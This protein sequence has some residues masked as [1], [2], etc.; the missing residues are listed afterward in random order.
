MIKSEHPRR[1]ANITIYETFYKY[2]SSHAQTMKRCEWISTQCQQYP[3]WPQWLL[4]T[5]KPTNAFTP[6]HNK[7]KGS[8][9]LDGNE[10]HISFI[11]FLRNTSS[12]L[13]KLMHFNHESLYPELPATIAN[14]ADSKTT[15]FVGFFQKSTKQLFFHTF[16]HSWWRRIVSEL[17]CSKS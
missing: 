1:N 12:N 11:A 15:N 13:N 5:Y 6:F 7:S 4:Q 14:D 10:K 16:V 3:Q 8:W 17:Q 9:R 2:T